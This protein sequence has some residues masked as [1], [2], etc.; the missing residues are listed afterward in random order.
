M[1]FALADGQAEENVDVTGVDH[2]Q[3]PS[4]H[5]SRP[6]SVRQPA[7]VPA[8]LQQPFGAGPP[9]TPDPRFGRALALHH[10]HQRAEAAAEEATAAT[11]RTT[12]G[13]K[14]AQAIFTLAHVHEIEMP[15]TN[16]ISALLDENVTLNQA[17][18]A[19]TS[20]PPRPS[21]EP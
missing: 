15:I 3:D 10:G 14:S 21:A 6:A 18:A 4:D 17:A 13:V 8:L 5:A 7:P 2:A 19:L 9:R 11:R 20:G 12:E 1:V 16:V